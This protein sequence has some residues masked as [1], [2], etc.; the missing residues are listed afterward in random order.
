MTSNQTEKIKKKIAD[1]KRTLA[2]EKRKFGAYDDSRGLRY[3]PT[4]LYIKLGDFSGALK[5]TKW[6]HKNFPDDCGFPDFLFEWTIILFKTGNLKDAEKKAFETFCSNT[7]LF[8]KFFDRPILPLD[9]YEFSNTDTPEFCDYFEYSSGQAE[10]SDF[11]EW[12]SKYLASEKFITL[13]TK[14]IEINKRLNIEDDTE[15]RGY[16][17]NQI[18]QLEDQA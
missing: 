13:S 3:L 17:I 18:S 11:S 16:L 1:I 2:A 5:Y 10:L 15:T 12:L 4:N 14:F 6:F 9:K 7:Y 8:A